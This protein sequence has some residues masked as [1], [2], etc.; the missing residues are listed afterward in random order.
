[1]GLTDQCEFITDMTHLKQH[2][3]TPCSHC[4]GLSVS[5]AHDTHAHANTQRVLCTYENAC[6]HSRTGTYAAAYSPLQLRV[7]QAVFFYPCF[8]FS[9]RHLIIHSQCTVS[10]YS[11]HLSVRTQIQCVHWSVSICHIDELPQS[12][13]GVKKCIGLH[14]PE[15]PAS[16]AGAHSV[17]YECI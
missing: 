16:S 14:R 5:D 17:S 2:T 4:H 1:M 11:A 7:C 3:H 8:W 12:A 10:S 6:A 9:S 13:L 15:S